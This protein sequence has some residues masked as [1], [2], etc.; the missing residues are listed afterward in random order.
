[1]VSTESVYSLITELSGTFAHA[2]TPFYTTKAKK[3]Q[4]LKKQTDHLRRRAFDCLLFDY[5]E[6]FSDVE[7]SQ[8]EQARC[9]VAPNYYPAHISE[10][11]QDNLDK[12]IHGKNIDV[13][14][15]S[16]TLLYLV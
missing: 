6:E 8:I 4:L 9:A 1:M 11:F 10:K 5:D 16:I 15:A 3:R 7:D 13:E 12:F 14:N 2:S